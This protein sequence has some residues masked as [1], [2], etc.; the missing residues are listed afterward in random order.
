MKS[1]TY[2]DYT[3]IDFLKDERFLRW[4]LFKSTEDALYWARLADQYPT[5][6]P[7]IEKAVTLYKE[8]IRFHDGGLSKKEITECVTAL[9]QEI[10]QRKRKKSAI[11]FLWG[12]SVAA[13]SVAIVMSLSALF[14]SSSQMQDIATFAQ[15]LN[16]DNDLLG[17]ETKLIV[18]ENNTVVLKDAESSV[19][20][21]QDAIKVDNN[22]LSKE[23]SSSY[24][25]LITPYG[26]RSVILFSDG[27]KAHVNAGSRLTYPIEF[28]KDKREI[29]VDGE[30]YIEVSKDE[31]RPFVIKTKQMQVE[32]LGTKFNL[33]AYDTDR[34]N[35]VV[36]LSGSVSISSDQC[37]KQVVLKPN[38]RYSHAEGSQHVQYVDAPAYI[39]WTQG[40]YQFESEKLSHIVA[41]LER[42]YAVRMECDSAAAEL[43]CSGKLDLKDDMHKL[44][45]DLAGALPIAYQQKADGSYLICIKK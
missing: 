17:D 11:R 3:A 9:L 27:T 20:Y 13:A 35:S 34:E 43:R 21:E 41:R 28:A 39:L 6:K 8:N 23:E 36:L 25:Q 7:E 15:S 40:L 19:Q 32:V 33:S 42:Y 18:S 5:L 2:K 24:N 4:Q 12:I 38:Q 44:F 10:H 14:P 1:D 31:K 22:I 29:Y 45:D 26:K 37:D 16:N 30:I